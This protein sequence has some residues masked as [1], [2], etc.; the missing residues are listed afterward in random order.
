MIRLLTLVLLLLTLIPSLPA[1][2]FDWPVSVSV[3]E[4]DGNRMIWAYGS[5][6]EGRFRFAGEYLNIRPFVDV[7]SWSLMHENHWKKSVIGPRISATVGTIGQSTLAGVYH[8][9]F[10]PGKVFSLSLF[11]RSWS[12]GDYTGQRWEF[13]SYF[14]REFPLFKVSDTQISFVPVAY[15]ERVRFRTGWVWGMSLAATRGK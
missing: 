13:A 14:I 5:A 11:D 15:Y 12:F 6:R 7:A 10:L 1:Q 4:L 9:R 8:R 3:G 2:V